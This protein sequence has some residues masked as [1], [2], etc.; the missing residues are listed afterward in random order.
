MNTLCNFLVESKLIK[1]FEFSNGV[2]KLTSH[3]GE[4]FEYS[5]KNKSKSIRGLNASS[6]E[7]TSSDEVFRRVSFNYFP[8]EEEDYCELGK[9]LLEEINKYVR[10]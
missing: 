7:L 6:I 3:S 5:A 8:Q 9:E 10:K 4:V 2:L 1:S